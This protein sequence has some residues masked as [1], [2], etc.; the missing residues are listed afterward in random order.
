MTS[1]IIASTLVNVGTV[2]SVSAMRLAANVSFA[3]A[4]LMTL[5]TLVTLL[6]IRKAE[7][8]EAMITGAA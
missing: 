2:L 8:K 7:R 4:A 1:A 5:S 6:R 3:G